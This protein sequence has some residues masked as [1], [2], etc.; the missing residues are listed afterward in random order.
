MGD[1][2]DLRSENGEGSVLSESSQKTETEKLDYAAWSNEVEELLSEWA[3]KAGCF[4]WLHTRSEKKYRRRYYMFSI[5]VII[6]STL[7]GTANFGMDSYVP[8]SGQATAT[9]VVGGLNIFAGILSTLQNFLKVAENME[10]NRAAGVAWS[11]LGRNISIELALDPKRRTKATDFLKLSRAEYDRLIEQS[12]IV[13]DDI[14]AQFQAKFKGYEYKPR[15][16]NSI[17]VPSI[18]NGLEKCDVFKQ[19]GNEVL[20]VPDVPVGKG[21]DDDDDDPE[22]GKT[23]IVSTR[24]D[25]V[26]VDP[27]TPMGEIIKETMEGSIKGLAVDIVPDVKGLV[28]DLVPED[29]KDK[30]D[31]VKDKLDGV[32]ALADIAEDLVPE[33]IKD[34]IDDA[35]AIADVADSLSESFLGGIVDRVAGDEGEGEAEAEPEPAPE[36]EAKP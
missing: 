16:E 33:D 10:A 29:L 12:P 13:D 28:G 3:E 34:K 25:I 4:R 5:P 27:I 8:E 26:S 21:D 35:K 22:L 24:P 6:L 11:K 30:L 36:P 15:G 14:V 31:G 2:I 18:C 1:A 7:T 32:K 17:A 23:K 19:E 20:E 9:A